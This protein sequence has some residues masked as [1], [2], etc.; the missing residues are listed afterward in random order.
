MTTEIA[1][2]ETQAG[3]TKGG[4]LFTGFLVLACLGLAVE[5]LLLVRENRQLKERVANLSTTAQ[6]PT[7]QAGAVFEDLSLRDEAGDESRIEFGE[8]Q[9]HTLLLAFTLACPAC[10]RN[11]PIWSEIV[12]AEDTPRLRVRAVRLDRDAEPVEASINVLPLPLYS[13]VDAREVVALITHVP[14][15]LLLDEWGIVEHAWTGML[16]PGDQ[17][18]LRSAIA[19]VNQT[20]D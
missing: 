12:P 6:P 5:T 13:L 16:E 9:P 20:G 17:A 1:A 3:A 8:G 11:L 7:I 4:R 15:T 18:E 19:S 2:P 14:T 10:E